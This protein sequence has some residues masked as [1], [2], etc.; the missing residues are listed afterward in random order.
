MQ[1]EEL[2]KQRVYTRRLDFYW[3][4]IAVYAIAL[5]VYALMKGTVSEKTISFEF[6]DP[7]VLLLLVFII[8]TNAALIYQYIKRKSIIISDNGFS[9]KTRF[10]EKNYPLNLIRRIAF[11]RERRIRTKKPARMIKIRLHNRRFP[12][13]IRPSAFTNEKEMESDFI[14]LKKILREYRNLAK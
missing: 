12:L 6:W 7:V 10:K 5:L 3:Q 11:S 9:L 13:R 2:K 8:S 4:Y 1:E 14:K